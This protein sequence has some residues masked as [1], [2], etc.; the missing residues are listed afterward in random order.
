MNFL[1]DFP[2]T[3]IISQTAVMA[4]E[5]PSMNATPVQ[6]SA[7]TSSKTMT[8]QEAFSSL[9]MSFPWSTHSSI[10]QST[11]TALALLRN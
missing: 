8:F 2:G 1:R 6:N 11:W 9:N 7:M 5:L 4:L 10:E 3:Q